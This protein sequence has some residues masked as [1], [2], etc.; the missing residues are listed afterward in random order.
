MIVMASHSAPRVDF[1]TRQLTGNQ[2]TQGSYRC[3]CARD[4]DALERLRGIEISMVIW[5]G[6]PPNDGVQHYP[7]ADYNQI[8]ICKG[9]LKS[10]LR[11]APQVWI[12]I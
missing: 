9:T 4:K 5:D 6:D 7:M 1:W 3:I 11:K 8:S 2:Q 10:M 12:T